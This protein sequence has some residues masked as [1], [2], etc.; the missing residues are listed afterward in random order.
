MWTAIRDADISSSVAVTRLC[1]SSL[2]VTQL[3]IAPASY[4]Q[5]IQRNPAYVKFNTEKL[6][7]ADFRLQFFILAF[8]VFSAS[9]CSFQ[10]SSNLD[11]LSVVFY[12][13]SYFFGQ[14]SANFSFFLHIFS[15]FCLCLSA[16]FIY[17]TNLVTLLSSVFCNSSYLLVMFILFF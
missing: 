9:F 16:P 8:S 15:F 10:L 2:R 17:S 12:K 11:V 5:Q 13:L 1:N 6:L 4:F 3:I 7:S 14:F